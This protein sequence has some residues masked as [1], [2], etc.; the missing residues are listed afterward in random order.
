MEDVPWGALGVVVRVLVR[1]SELRTLD[2]INITDGRRLGNVFD[3]DLNVDTGAIKALVV[4]GER[5]LFSFFRAGPDLEIP[6]HRI[7][8]IGVDVILVEMPEHAGTIGHR[9]ESSP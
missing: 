8:K 9:R 7:V 5:G 2:V 6:W 1:A 4:P 3:L